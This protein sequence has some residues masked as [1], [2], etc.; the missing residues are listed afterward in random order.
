LV[1]EFLPSFLLVARRCLKT[2]SPS[3]AGFACAARAAAGAVANP[4]H[5]LTLLIALQ[6]VA[7][8]ELVER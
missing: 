4:L 2:P 6:L 7:E 1:T 8:L 3:T 5:A